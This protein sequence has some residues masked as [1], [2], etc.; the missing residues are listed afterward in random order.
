M[1]SANK[2]VP[3]QLIVQEALQVAREYFVFSFIQALM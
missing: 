2:P 1:P 3:G